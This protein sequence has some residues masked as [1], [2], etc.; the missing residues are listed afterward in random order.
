MENNQSIHA[1]GFHVG[2]SSVSHRRRS[3]GR[4][5]QTRPRRISSSSSRTVISTPSLAQSSSSDNEQLRRISIEYCT[6]CKWMLRAAWMSQE[7]LTTFQDELYSVSMIPSKPPS[8][9]G[10]FLITLNDTIVIWNRKEEGRFPEAKEVK[11]RI[12]DWIRPERSLGH[13]DT[14][15]RKKGQ[16][17]QQVNPHNKISIQPEE[18]DDAEKRTTTVSVT[19]SIEY[20]TSTSIISSTGEEK[21][22]ECIDERKEFVKQIQTQFSDIDDNEAQEMK[23][24]YG[25]L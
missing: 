2:V 19:E 6:G 3:E 5:L 24:F 16:Q 18:Q 13:S 20:T 11:Q 25:V 4:V 10:T 22:D 14:E 17:E 1:F 7:L 9:A 8:P 15:D 21:C 12:R 23:R